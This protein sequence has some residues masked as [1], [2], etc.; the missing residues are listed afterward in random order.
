MDRLKI[1]M[2]GGFW[3]SAGKESLSDRS[4]NT[5]LL[6][7]YLIVFKNR[8]VMRGELSKLLGI[9]E[10]SGAL[11][12]QIHRSKAEIKRLTDDPVIMSSRG[13]YALNRNLDCFYDFEEFERL[14]GE[15]LT[16]HRKAEKLMLLTRAIE[17]YK[18]EFLPSL[19]AEEWVAPKNAHY[20][21]VYVSAV[22]SAVNLLSEEGRAGEVIPLCR[23]AVSVEPGEKTLHEMFVRALMNEGDRKGAKSHY[24]YANELLNGD[25]PDGIYAELD[26][27]DSG[28]IPDFGEAVDSLA[29]D[30]V[31]GA[32]YC[33][34]EVFKRAYLLEI[35]RAAR[36][37]R[38]VSV[39]LVTIIRKSGKKPDK[40]VL[41]EA[42]DTLFEILL[43]GLRLGDVFARYSESQY[44]MMLRSTNTRD[45]CEAILERLK[46]RYRA[47][48]I[49]K[50]EDFVY[51]FQPI[52]ESGGDI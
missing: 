2:F 24:L 29:E 41:K 11:N 13:V 51:E 39:F 12:A 8:D 16:A 7:A 26:S 43:G 22:E 10:S 15:A 52:K 14:Y 21:A 19:S 23:T 38:S 33:V 18:G 45:A 28:K 17:L 20:R 1:T 34:Y 5:R 30:N 27:A 44:I 9:A 25:L 49:S 35:R 48:N 4:R 47:E 32:F 3:V 46:E 6:L 50:A 36:Q 42:M 40:N 31:S 37:N